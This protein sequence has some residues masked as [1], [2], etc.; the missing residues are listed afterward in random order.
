ML[1]PWSLACALKKTPLARNHI[2]LFQQSLTVFTRQSSPL[3]SVNIIDGVVTC[4]ALVY[5][6]LDLVIVGLFADV[7]YDVLRHY[8][9]K[10][11]EQIKAYWSGIT[12]DLEYNHR[13]IQAAPN[14]LKPMVRDSH[15]TIIFWLFVLQVEIVQNIK[16]AQE[17]GVEK[18][19]VWSVQSNFVHAGPST[20]G[21]VVNDCLLHTNTWFVCR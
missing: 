13:M 5:C 10:H 20:K 21:K 12:G 9:D 15:F 4:F 3:V 18:G 16:P 19:D 14:L 8:P 11:G 7:T 2:L 1:F 17:C 6:Q